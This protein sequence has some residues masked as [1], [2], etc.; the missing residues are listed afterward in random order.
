MERIPTWVFWVA[1]LVFAAL[2]VWSA[3]DENWAGL[4]IGALLAVAAAALAT[5]WRPDSR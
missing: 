5:G 4:I 3:T 2:A 1:A